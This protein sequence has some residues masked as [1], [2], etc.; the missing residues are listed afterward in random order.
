MKKL[1][2]IAALGA[3]SAAS[4]AWTLNKTPDIGP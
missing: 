3:V 1:L 2:S 4:F